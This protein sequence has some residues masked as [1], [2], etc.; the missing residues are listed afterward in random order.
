MDIKIRTEKENFKYRVCGILKHDDKY[1]GVKIAD[2]EFFCLPGG[3]VEIGEDTDQ[4]AKR[5]MAEELGFPIKITRLAGMAQNFFKA[6]NGGQFHEL[7]FYYIVE[8]EDPGM[9]NTSDYEIIENDKGELKKLVF[10]WF[11]KKDIE[12]VDF[13]PVFVKDLIA[14]EDMLSIVLRDEKIVKI[15]KYKKM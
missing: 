4:A 1:L 11:T 5:E 10:K 9:V 3:H 14:S 13:R 15:D 6:K 2:N 7:G 8:A 12:T